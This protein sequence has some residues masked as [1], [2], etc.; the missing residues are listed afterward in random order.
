MPKILLV[1]DNQ[2]SREGLA[3]RLERRGYE[4]VLGLR[5]PPGSESGRCRCPG[6]DSDGHQLT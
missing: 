6:P 5:R 2:D 4:V 1:E 3:R